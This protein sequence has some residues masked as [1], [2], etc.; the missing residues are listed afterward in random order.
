MKACGND[1]SIIDT[2]VISFGKKDSL[3]MCLNLQVL[4]GRTHRADMK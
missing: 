2:K 3:G 1:H 4:Y